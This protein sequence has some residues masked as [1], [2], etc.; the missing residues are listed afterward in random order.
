M[1]TKTKKSALLVLSTMALGT[2][3][4]PTMGALEVS[5]QT[6]KKQS[7]VVDSVTARELLD[8]L[9]VAERYRNMDLF[10]Y[11]KSDALVK[12]PSLTPTEQ[13]RLKLEMNT[14]EQNLK[15]MVLDQ[16]NKEMSPYREL[17]TNLDVASFTKELSGIPVNAP[18]YRPAQSLKNQWIQNK[19]KW[20]FDAL[21][22]QSQSTPL[23]PSELATLEK[24]SKSLPDSLVKP[25]QANVSELKNAQAVKQVQ[26]GVALAERAPDKSFIAK[27]KVEA[28]KLASSSAKT[29]LLVKI[30][31]L[32]TKQRVISPKEFHSLLGG[33]VENGQLGRYE[34]PV[35]MQEMVKQQLSELKKTS[36][37][38]YVRLAKVFYGE[39][40]T[41]HYR[42][43]TRDS[44]VSIDKMKEFQSKV[45]TFERETGIVNDRDIVYMETKV[46]ELE[47]RH[48]YARA[49]KMT[50]YLTDSEL[51]ATLKKAYA[52]GGMYGNQIQEKVDKA[53]SE[54]AYTFI[55]LY[56]STGK[57]PADY[58]M[59]LKKINEIK[60]DSIKVTLLKQLNG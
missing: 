1:K 19:A 6:S 12:L 49:M 5:A 13:A 53:K 14:K 34:M 56:Q 26:A 39:E 33:F 48:E 28:N 52:P 35:F 46:S 16:Q 51:T 8:R 27:V 17:L 31:T 59:A 42:V 2:A 43:L 41:Q 40:V 18:Q 7:V 30:K 24:L 44:M 20:D 21:M 38:R 32:E 22:I 58:Q 29:S 15:L 11:V 60:S 50:K 47:T 10:N 3:V 55:R 4:V 36:P 37:T 25:S 23:S 57:K 9:D 54:N 45:A